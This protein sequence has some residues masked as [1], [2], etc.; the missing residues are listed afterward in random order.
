MWAS[1]SCPFA[2][3]TRN[4]ALGNGV[5]TTPST[6]IASFFPMCSLLS[7]APSGSRSSGR[8]RRTLAPSQREHFGLT[9]RDRNRVLKVGREAAVQRAHGPPVVMFLGAPV[10]QVH[11]GLD[12]DH[13]PF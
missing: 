5:L 4:V 9:V 11:H 12:G 2:R 7:L 10:A 13:H 3:S 8:Q 1:T 6:S